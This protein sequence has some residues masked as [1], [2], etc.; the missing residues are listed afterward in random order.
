MKDTK[1]ILLGMLS[2][3]LVG[4]WVFYF[5]DKAHISKQAT[6]VQ[7]STGLAEKVKD[8]L[9][10]VYSGTLSQMDYQL[11]TT[12]SNADSLKNELGTKLNEIS[13]LRS[14]I[15]SILRGQHTSPAELDIAKA[16][17]TELQRK[18][19]ELTNQKDRMAAEKQQLMALLSELSGKSDGVRNDIVKLGDENKVLADKVSQSTVFT[20]S[21]IRLSPVESGDAGRN[22]QLSVAFDVRNN[23]PYS[24]AELF[25]VVI[26]PDG[27]VLRNDVWETSYIDTRSYGRKMY[28]MKLRFDYQKGENKHLMFNLNAE[29]VQ[30]GNYTLQLYQNGYLIGQ[31]V[32]VVS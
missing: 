31:A 28:T 29:E 10:Q 20:V 3:G 16:R 22:G 24:N 2:V 18:I 6:L 5:Y 23:A 1:T 12:R 17:I 30:R 26:Q 8:S 14:E 13:Q 11:D 4:T 9:R 27:K 25:I 19:N 15:D 21:D 32:K 7:N